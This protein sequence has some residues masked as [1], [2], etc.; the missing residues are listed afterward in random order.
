MHQWSPTDH[1]WCRF[2]YLKGLYGF[3]ISS[4]NFYTKHTLFRYCNNHRTNE[5]TSSTEWDLA[6]R[7]AGGRFHRLRQAAAAIRDV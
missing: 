1:C 4:V 2:H 6:H 5:L 7:A 3:G